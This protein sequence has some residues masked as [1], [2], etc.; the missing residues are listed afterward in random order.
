MSEPRQ[1]SDIMV[2][3]MQSAYGEGFLSPGGPRELRAILQGLTVTGCDI[4]DLGCGVGGGL[5]LLAGEMGAGR[6]VGLDV[7]A[8]S[9][10]RAQSALEGAGLAACVTLVPAEPGPLPLPDAG[11]DIVYS[12]DV[13]CHVPDKAALFAEV[14]R[15]LRPGGVFAFGDW[16]HG[17]QGQGQALF[18]DWLAQLRTAGLRF[19]YEDIAAYQ[20]ALADAGF[21]AVESVDNSPWAEA[22]AQEQLDDAAGPS[23]DQAI[24]ALG[25]AA[26]ERR[27][28]LTRTR[29]EALASGSL[30]H[31]HLRATKGTV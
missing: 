27:L 6:V 25:E 7:E 8:T 3:S 31:W 23:R 11:F 18:D 22:I 24:T 2:E 5:R 13:I 1:Y 17:P 9:L 16:I 29:L 30:Q 4:L 26:Y 21:A 14:L 28:R 10:A 15:V 19:W 12:N 20:R